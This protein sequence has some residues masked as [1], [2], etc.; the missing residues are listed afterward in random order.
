MLKNI[1]T[2]GLINPKFHYHDLFSIKDYMTNYQD[3][4]IT[5]DKMVCYIENEEDFIT[6]YDNEL[7]DKINVDCF[8]INNNEKIFQFLTK[9]KQNSKMIDMNYQKN[10]IIFCFGKETPFLMELEENNT[11]YLMG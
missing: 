9:N 4:K 1:E 10:E 11:L 2:I 8:Y 7:K 3:K 6:Y 5:L